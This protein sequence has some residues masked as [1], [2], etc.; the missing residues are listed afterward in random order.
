MSIKVERNFLAIN[1]VKD[2]NEPKSNIKEISISLLEPV[3]FQINK[4]FYKNIGKNH[5][6]IDRLIWTEKQWIE[7]TCDEKVKTYILKKNDEEL[8][9][10]IHNEK[11]LGLLKK[12]DY[13]IVWVEL[14]D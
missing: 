6:W 2:L 3:D 11:N 14:N 9:D 5:N 13:T 1:S 10:W 8:K 4:F 12:D 7:Y